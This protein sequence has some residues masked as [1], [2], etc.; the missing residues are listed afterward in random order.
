L[1]LATSSRFQWRLF[2]D[3]ETLPGATVAFS[4]RA[5]RPDALDS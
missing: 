2:I 4:T 5:P 3:G 1:E